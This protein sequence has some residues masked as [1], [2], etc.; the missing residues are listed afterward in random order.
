MEKK[1]RKEK[2]RQ[3]NTMFTQIIKSEEGSKSN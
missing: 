3:S 1:E 2:F